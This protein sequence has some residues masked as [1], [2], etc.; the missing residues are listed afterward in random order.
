MLL[1]YI[2]VEQDADDILLNQQRQSLMTAGV[3]S[4]HAYTDIGCHRHDS[5]PGRQDCLA[6]LNAGDTL[7]VWKLERLIDSRAH[8]LEVLTSIRQRKAGLKVL[9]GKGVVVDSSKLSLDAIAQVVEAV[10]DL[11]AQVNREA[12]MAGRAIAKAKG[13]TFGPKHKVTAAIL[14]E[15]IKELATTDAS[16]TAVAE[17]R[18]LTRATLYNYLNGDGSLKPAGQKMLEAHPED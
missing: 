9:E 6:A 10:A 7:V 15:I 14:R 1:G 12:S 13:A 5:R 11:E 2:W 16:F 4:E 17:N 8:F 3:L 18:G